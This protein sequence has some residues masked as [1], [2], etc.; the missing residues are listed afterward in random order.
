[1][2]LL[3]LIVL[4]II[5]IVIVIEHV[6]ILPVNSDHLLI[7]IDTNEQ[8]VVTRL[9]TDRS[10]IPSHSHAHIDM[11]TC[12][13]VSLVPLAAF[14]IRRKHA[15]GRV[16][17][18]EAVGTRTSFSLVSKAHPILIDNQNAGTSPSLTGLDPHPA[19]RR[20]DA[21]IPDVVA[22]R[23]LPSGLAAELGL[24]A[25]EVEQKAGQIVLDLLSGEPSPAVGTGGRVGVAP[26]QSACNRGGEQR[27]AQCPGGRHLVLDHD[28][29]PE[30]LGE[31]TNLAG[32]L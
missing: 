7:I 26:G 25:D 2:S 23:V 1:M 14:V 9:I 3:I 11:T 10:F 28:V 29:A 16:S 4:V 5:V 18:E 31:A 6:L 17:V 24:D 32:V 8:L 22:F 27:R 20:N 15:S 12:P 30:Q 19:R 21:S 13:Q